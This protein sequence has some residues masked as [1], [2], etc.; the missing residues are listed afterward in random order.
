[1]PYDH[2][3]YLHRREVSMGETTAGNAT[4]HSK[5]AV[6][7]RMRLKSVQ[8]SITVAGTTAGATLTARTVVGTV[9]TSV[10]LMTLT[11]SAAGVMASSGALNVAL[12]PGTHLTLTNGTDATAR[13]IPVLELEVFPDAVQTA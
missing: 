4:V 13:C 7:Q 1:M 11:T 3:N 2:P 5:F 8:A 9:T 12:E 6:F 10:G